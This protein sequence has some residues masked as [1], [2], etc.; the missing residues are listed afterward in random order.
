M[1]QCTS[2][3]SSLWEAHHYSKCEY[4][5]PE[6]CVSC[7]KRRCKSSTEIIHH[8]MRWWMFY[9]ERN[10]HDASVILLRRSHS[11]ANWLRSC[12]LILFTCVMETWSI[13]QYCNNEG[14]KERPKHRNWIELTSSIFNARKCNCTARMIYIYCLMLDWSEMRSNCITLL[15]WTHDY[16]MMSLCTTVL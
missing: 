14:L 8:E 4:F 1:F 5:K 11:G 3:T 6:R 13:L 10:T 9:A 12:R 7:L 15:E 16:G 2:G